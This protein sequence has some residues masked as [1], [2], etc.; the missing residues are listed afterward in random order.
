M[1]LDIDQVETDSNQIVS[2]T[3][4]TSLSSKKKDLIFDHEFIFQDYFQNY[5]NSIE[6]T[7]EVNEHCKIH[8][9]NG[10]DNKNYTI[11][12]I[13]KKNNNVLVKNPNMKRAFKLYKKQM[14]EIKKLSILPKDMLVEN[15]KVKLTNA[16]K[17]ISYKI[18]K[19]HVQEISNSKE[20]DTNRKEEC[21]SENI[22]QLASFLSKIPNQKEML[23]INPDYFLFMNTQKSPKKVRSILDFQLIN[24][25]N[26]EMNDQAFEKLKIKGK[27]YSKDDIGQ[28]VYVLFLKL[29]SKIL[30]IKEISLIAD[31]FSA[32]KLFFETPLNENKIKTSQKLFDYNYKSKSMKYISEIILCII[33][34][35]SEINQKQINYFL[36]KI[37]STYFIEANFSNSSLIQFN[38]FDLVEK[39]DIYNYNQFWEEKKQIEDLIR[40]IKQFWGKNL[41]ENFLSNLISVIQSSK[42]SLISLAKTLNLKTDS[43]IDQRDLEKILV[44]SIHQILESN[45]SLLKSNEELKDIID[46]KNQ[47]IILLEQNINSYLERIKMSEN[48]KENLKELLL[49]CETKIGALEEI[50]KLKKENAFLKEKVSDLE[51]KDKTIK[52]QTIEIDR[53]NKE[54]DCQNESLKIH[55]NEIIQLSKNIENIIQDNKIKEHN[56][57]LEFEK[58]SQKLKVDLNNDK[59]NEIHVIQNINEEEINNLKKELEISESEKNK[60]IVK[61]DEYSNQLE[62]L[63]SQAKENL[64]MYEEEKNDLNKEIQNQ[65]QNASSLENEILFLKNQ[66]EDLNKIL[67]EKE[68]QIS[69]F[70]DN[71]ENYRN[72]FLKP[73][74]LNKNV[75]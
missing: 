8:F 42:E 15:V 32:Q 31:D 54:I 69:N 16:D 64:E 47:K 41:R 34:T 38:Y 68:L 52:E 67:S 36:N 65:M 17:K 14:L 25:Y 7:V 51:C 30:G 22:R 33:N 35:Y 60:M 10:R 27:N 53:L 37:E 58:E 21:I 26:F 1:K 19:G 44:D 74:D 72:Q 62:L 46:K 5:I 75:I 61:N 45:T 48:E 39:A 66:K 12:E 24:C 11:F 49:E 55:Q 73:K 59:M 13:I 4:Y 18:L 71:P 20:I 57:K 6:S 70:F 40:S 63:K 43:I 28:F 2:P 56:M 23:L 29:I 3:H 9:C 50:Q